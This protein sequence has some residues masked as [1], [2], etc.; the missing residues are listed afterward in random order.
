MWFNSSAIGFSTFAPDFFASKGHSL[1]H[2]GALAS[3]LMWGPLA[4]S[5]VIGRLVDKVGNNDLFIA[6]G[7]AVTSGTIY[8]VSRTT[9]LLL[10][11][12]VMAVAVALIPASIYSFTSRTMKPES[13]GLGF[14]ILSTFSS[15][16]MVF[17]PYTAGLIKDKTGSYE[18]SFV[19]LCILALLVALTAVLL[20]IKTRRD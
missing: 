16:G 2:A 15:I 20:R 5:P 7:G 10:P 9:D 19:F 6:A 11:M 13:L 12:V 4:L 18:S 14:G 1:T 17:G 8:L 3:L